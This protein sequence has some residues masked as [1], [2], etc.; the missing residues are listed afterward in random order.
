M[1]AIVNPETYAYLTARRAWTPARFERRLGDSLTV[2]LL[3]PS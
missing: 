2:L 1:S 3:P